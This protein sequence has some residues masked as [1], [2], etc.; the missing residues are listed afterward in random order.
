MK[1][2][3]RISSLVICA[4]IGAAVTHTPSTRAMGVGSAIATGALLHSLWTHYKALPQ[5]VKERPSE[6]DVKELK[7]A[8]KDFACGKDT[9]KNA[10]KIWKNIKGLYVDGL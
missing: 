5:D 8:L 4:A 6:Y 3:Q 10:K 1:I 7:K 2:T 9:K